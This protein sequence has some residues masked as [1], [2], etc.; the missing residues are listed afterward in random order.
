MTIQFG[1]SGAEKQISIHDDLSFV[2]KQDVSADDFDTPAYT[3]DGPDGYLLG[4]D[5]GTPVAPEFRDSNGDKLDDSTRVEIQ[6]CDRQG[7]RLGGGIVFSELLG[8]FD[9]TKFRNDPEFFRK[10]KKALMIDEREIVK[11]FVKVPSGSNGFDEANSRL[12]IG[13]DTS[14]FGKS[15]EIVDHDDLSPAEKAAVKQASQNSTGSA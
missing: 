8:R 14:D 13:D 11:V 4:V 1:T 9:Y 3:I 12:T 6:K 5:S 7:N 15:V 2:S 10:T